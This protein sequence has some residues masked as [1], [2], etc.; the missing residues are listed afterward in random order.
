[1]VKAVRPD[2]DLCV[3]EDERL[4]VPRAGSAVFGI[5]PS[6][7]MLTDTYPDM[8][9]GTCQRALLERPFGCAETVRSQTYSA[10]R[11]VAVTS[12]L[13]PNLVDAS[14]IAAI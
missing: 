3:V 4:P 14:I 12:S 5:Y 13:A 8:S 2:R 1:V 6:K 11:V 10:A 7:H 9:Y